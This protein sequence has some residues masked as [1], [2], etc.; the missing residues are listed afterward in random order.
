[1]ADSQQQGCLY[2]V[3]TPIGNL[4]DITLRAIR[5]LREVDLVAAEDTRHARI[6]LNRIE[7]R[8]PT[9]SL[10]EANEEQRIPGIIE[11]LHQGTTIALISD[12]GTPTLSDPGYRLAKAC[13][14]E[15]LTVEVIPG[16]SAPIQA[17]LLSGLS[18]ARFRFLGFLPRKGRARQ[19]LVREIAAAR[20]TVLFFESP[21]RLAA[22]LD[23]LA[24]E[25]GGREV[26]VAREMTKLHEE[27]LRGRADELAERFRE[28][29]PRGEITVAVTGREDS[30]PLEG[31]AL[32]QEIEQ[33]LARGQG[34]RQ[35]AEALAELGKRRVYQLA[36]SLRDRLH[37]SSPSE[38]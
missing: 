4:E 16:P 33:R 17:L 30:A 35:I 31:P 13:R 24:P 9:L 21:R 18:P 22:T 8:T 25:L 38:A 2:L 23:D 26:A 36:L 6:L 14:A 3:A 5:V 20:D 15:G 37:D 27:V 29:P 12:A 1:M 32:E 19:D 11:K 7:V 34:P 28:T 10:F